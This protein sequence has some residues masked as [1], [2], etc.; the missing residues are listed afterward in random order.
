M[1]ERF[2]E[3]A[4][5]VIFFARYEASLWGDDYIH[6]EHLLLGLLREDKQLF[7]ALLHSSN[8]FPN[9]AEELGLKQT[10]KTVSVSVDLPL[11]SEAKR[12]L[13]FGAEEAELLGSSTIETGHLLL[14]LLREPGPACNLLVKHGLT[15]PS[16][17]QLVKGVA[18]KAVGSEQ[19]VAN[20]RSEFRG[21]I[22]GQLKPELE[23][24]V[25]YGMRSG[26]AK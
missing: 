8:P 15:L 21:V 9:A 13:A 1:F 5:R 19:I 16:L 14:G 22:M 12:V 25:E 6:T 2:S 7:N 3:K 18:Q 24:A 20:L 11:S 23:P 4:R 17:R 10:G 26:I